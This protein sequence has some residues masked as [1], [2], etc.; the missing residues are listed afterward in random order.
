MRFDRKSCQFS[1]TCN[2][3]LNRP[4]EASAWNEASNRRKSSGEVKLRN[5]TGG[6]T[7]SRHLGQALLGA[8]AG[9]TA[10]SAITS[11]MRRR[12]PATAG[13]SL[14]MQCRAL[15]V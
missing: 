13:L 7:L 15:L 11:F 12:P 1:F 10:G 6:A 4:R 5:L 14:S 8:H 9:K 3:D 2:G